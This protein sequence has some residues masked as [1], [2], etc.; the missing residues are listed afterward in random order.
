MRFT[1]KRSRF[2]L[3]NMIC[4][5]MDYRPTI[6]TDHGYTESFHKA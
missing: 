4:V 6:I 5:M 2:L 3:D 1:L